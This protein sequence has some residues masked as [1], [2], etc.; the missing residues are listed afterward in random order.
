MTPWDR[1]R[2]IPNVAT[3]LKPGVTLETLQH[4]ASQMSDNEAA[5]RLNTART[6]LFQSIHRRSRTAA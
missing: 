2:S 5:Q 1:L 4:Q 3:A 6:T